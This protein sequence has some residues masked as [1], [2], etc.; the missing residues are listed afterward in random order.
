MDDTNDI[1]ADFIEEEA[2]SELQLPWLLDM[3]YGI[4]PKIVMLDPDLTL[5]AKSILAFLYSF[6]GSGNSECYP[7]QDYIKSSL[8][9]GNDRFSRHFDYL[10]DQQ[11]FALTKKLIPPTGKKNSNTWRY[12]YILNEHPSKFDSHRADKKLIAEYDKIRAGSVFSAGYGIIPKRV[13]TDSSLA[14]EEKAIYAFLC[15]FS[16]GFDCA[17]DPRYTSDWDISKALYMSKNTLY[18]YLSSLCASPYV[19]KIRSVNGGKFGCRS[20]ILISNASKRSP[21]GGSSGAAVEAGETET[22]LPKIRSTASFP[23]NGSAAPFPK[24]GSAVPLLKNGSEAPIPE[25]ESSSRL[26]DMEET[27]PLPKNGSTAPLPK[28]PFPKIPLP[29]NPL[30]TNQGINNTCS[31]STVPNNTFCD[32]YRSSSSAVSQEED[33][34]DDPKEV[35]AERV[36]PV[37]MR[38]RKIPLELL[39]DKAAVRSLIYTA[40]DYGI[41]SDP[42]NYRANRD[43]NSSRFVFAASCFEQ[44]LLSPNN[45]IKIGEELVSKE[46]L[47]AAV[48]RNLDVAPDIDY[49]NINMQFIFDARDRYMEAEDTTR[50]ISP[51]A[52]MRT[53]L[54]DC[55]HSPDMESPHW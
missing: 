46:E 51:R 36:R 7:S 40:T 41:F 19:L 32:Q 21:E 12:L 33:D 9:I 55:L 8:K 45:S 38:E 1:I 16:G 48:N 43:M 31:N 35:F 27:A 6:T 26:F 23:R 2:S 10:R 3:G 4:L 29:T 53:V 11:Y 24:N 52:Y 15:V 25:S 17:I 34:S 5:E 20:F 49:L 13:L 28:K 37:I 39:N 30:P 42:A 47:L 14:V 18:K 50:I 54:W 44:M 22:P